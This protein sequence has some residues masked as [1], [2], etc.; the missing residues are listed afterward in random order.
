[1]NSSCSDW[2]HYTPTLPPAHRKNPLTP[3]NERWWGWQR[4]DGRGIKQKEESSQI[5]LQALQDGLE[6]TTP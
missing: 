6:P 3:K 4:L 2:Q 1:S 5:P